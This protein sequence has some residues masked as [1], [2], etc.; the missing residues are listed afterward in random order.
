MAYNKTRRNKSKRNKSEGGSCGINKN[1]GSMPMATM[2]GK[3]RN[4]TRRNKTEGGKRKMAKGASEWN[5]KVTE[6]YRKMKK[7]DSSVMFKDALVRA[8]ELKKKGQL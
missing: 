8:S 5:K 4:N 2:G 1:N 7:E 6:L 3:R